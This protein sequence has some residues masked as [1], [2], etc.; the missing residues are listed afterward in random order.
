[1]MA[2]KKKATKQS[3]KVTI[4]FSGLSDVEI[5]KK[6]KQTAKVMAKHSGAKIWAFAL[7]FLL[8]GVCFGIGTWWFVCS[9]DCFEIVGQT[10]V[11]LTLDEKYVDETVKIVAF[12]KDESHEFVIETNLEQD[13]E[14]KYYATEVGTY[15]I[16]YKATNWKYGKLFKIEKVRIITFVE[17]SEGGV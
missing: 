7:A 16:K 10:N 6:T 8:V 5:N 9:N 1:M 15:Y 13:Q 17:A 11:V 14:G 4:D 2:V 3:K 12:G